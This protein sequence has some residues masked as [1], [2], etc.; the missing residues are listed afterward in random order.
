MNKQIRTLLAFS[1]IGFSTSALPAIASELEPLRVT[2][3]F[4]FTAGHTNLPAGDYV[5]SES[6]AH[7]IFIRGQRGSAIIL[8]SAG[9][10]TEGDKSALSFERTEKG[11]YLKAIH[12]MGRPSSVLRLATYTDR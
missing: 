2:V 7:T 6:G 12:S 3:P 8:G 4:A 9:D 10:D 11:M 5:V 1:T